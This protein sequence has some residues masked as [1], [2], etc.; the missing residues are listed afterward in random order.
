[1]KKLISIVL[2]MIACL[3]LCTVSVLALTHAKG[4]VFTSPDDSAPYVDTSPSKTFEQEIVDTATEAPTEALEELNVFFLAPD[5]SMKTV[6]SLPGI[7]QLPSCNYAEE[8]KIFKG[9][10][11]SGEELLYSAGDQILLTEDI[12]LTAVFGKIPR[13]VKLY[14]GDSVDK[15]TCEE[16]RFILPLVESDEEGLVFAGWSVKADGPVVWHEG[17]TVDISSDMSFH[18]IFELKAYTV[19]FSAG[20]G[21]GSTDSLT[22]R[23]GE[24]IRLGTN[25]FSK[26][27]SA[28]KGYIDQYNNFYAIDTP[29]TVTEDMT[30]TAVYALNHTFSVRVNDKIEYSALYEVDLR[31]YIDLDELVRE[32]ATQMRITWTQTATAG[33]GNCISSLDLNC[34]KPV[35]NRNVFLRDHYEV[36]TYTSEGRIFSVDFSYTTATFSTK[37]IDLSEV[38]ESG[39]VSIHY[40]ALAFMPGDILNN[41]Y[42]IDATFTI[43]VF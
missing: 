12:V 36:A 25:G 8:G 1:M 24:S 10:S 15:I 30:L 19:S 33:I 21:S 7:Y 16:D 23:H 28:V 14:N 9:W 43:E 2:T 3:A 35:K 34:G 31:K 41:E 32:G 22:C 38:I 42:Y 17:E 40:K 4:A 18:A 6:K 5:G 39:C 11:L 29:L 37:A 13:N 26:S 27:K 20:E